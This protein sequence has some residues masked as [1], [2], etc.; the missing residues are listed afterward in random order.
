MKKITLVCT[1]F[2]CFLLSGCYNTTRV[3]YWERP[4]TGA[5][6]FSEDH[7]ACLYSADWFPWD[8]K[9]SRLWPF[10]PETL[11]LRL[12]L[13]NGG[14]WGNFVPYEGSQSIFVNTTVPSK[15]AIYAWYAMCMRN[16]GYKE[17]QKYSGPVKIK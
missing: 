5:T 6:Q 12:R 11:D 7:K 1:L 13:K 14:I 4:N 8:F 3:Y 2:S 15:T 9:F 17:R 16:H 10:T